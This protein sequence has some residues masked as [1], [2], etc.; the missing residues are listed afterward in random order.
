MTKLLQKEG[1]KVK[2]KRL[3]MKEG[4]KDYNICTVNTGIKLISQRKLF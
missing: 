1:E 3:K 2:D 4:G